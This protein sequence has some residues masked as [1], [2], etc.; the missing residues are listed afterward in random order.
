MVT[1]KRLAGTSCFSEALGAPRVVVR[2]LGPVAGDDF[3]PTETSIRDAIVAFP[4]RAA[5]VARVCA[6]LDGEAAA[7]LAADDGAPTKRVV[8]IDILLNVVTSIAG[9]RDGRIPA[10]VPESGGQSRINGVDLGDHFGLLLST[11]TL[12]FDGTVLSVVPTDTPH[13]LVRRRDAGYGAAHVIADTITIALDGVTVGLV[14][15]L[16]RAGAIDGGEIASDLGTYHDL[17]LVSSFVE[18]IRTQSPFGDTVSYRATRAALLHAGSGFETVASFAASFDPHDLY[19]GTR[20]FVRLL[21]EQGGDALTLTLPTAPGRPIRVKPD[22]GGWESEGAP[23]FVFTSQGQHDALK[24]GAREDLLTLVG[25]YAVEPLA[26]SSDGV[27]APS[28]SLDAAAVGLVPGFSASEAML[29]FSAADMAA[30][31][32]AKPLKVSFVLGPAFDPIVKP[33]EGPPLIEDEHTAALV[34]GTDPHLDRTSWMKLHRDGVMDLLAEPPSG[35]TL[36]G[37]ESAGA[38]ILSHA[39]LLRRVGSA[40]ETDAHAGF[41]PVLPPRGVRAGKL[42]LAKDF[43]RGLLARERRRASQAPRGARPGLAAM[44]VGAPRTTTTPLGFEIET[45]ESGSPT[46]IVFARVEIGAEAR[47]EAVFAL[48]GRDGRPLPSPVLDSL[49][50]NKLFLVANRMPDAVEAPDLVFENRINI[51]DYAFDVLLDAPAATLPIGATT[52]PFDTFVIVKNYAD[53]S[54]AEI[55]GDPS[56]WSGRGLFL[57]NPRSSGS[58]N[59]GQAASEVKKALEAYVARAGKIAGGETPPGEEA[60]TKADVA[61]FKRLFDSIL[62]DASWQGVFVIGASFNLGDLPPQLKGL[63]GGIDL[64]NLKAEYIAIPL[65]ALPSGGA[66]PQSRLQGLVDYRGPTGRPPAIE[67]DDDPPAGAAGSYGFDVPRLVVEFAR[68]EVLGFEARVRLVAKRLFHAIGNIQQKKGGTWKQADTI[69]LDGRYERRREGE[70]ML[71]S[72]VFETSTSYR[73]V[74]GSD[75]EGD[76]TAIV[77]QATLDRVAYETLSDD[78][79]GATKADVKSVFRINGDIAFGT[80]EIPGL[81]DLFNIDKIK[82]SDLRISCDF[83]LDLVNGVIDGLKKMS[84]RV[85]ALGFDFPNAKSRETGG[86][87]SSFPLKFRKFWMFDGPIDLPALGYF[88]FADFDAGLKFRFGFDFDLDLGT[89]GG[90]SSFKGLRLG[91]LFAFL[92]GGPSTGRFTLGFRFPEGDGSLDIGLQGFLKLKAERYGILDATYADGKKAK[93]L[94]SIGTQLQVLGQ[95][96]PAKPGVT[97]ALLVDPALIKSNGLGAVGWFAARKFDADSGKI[98]SVIDLELIALGQRVDPVHGVEVKTTKDFVE[99]LGELFAPGDKSG[100]ETGFGAG[101]PDPKKAAQKVV[102]VIEAGR[103]KFSPE[104]N[105]SLGFSAWI[106]DRVKIGLA[107]RDADIYGVR[108][109]LR[110][111]RT[112]SDPLFAVDVLYRK[113]SER[114]GVYSI[115]IVPP[116]SLRQIDL[117]WAVIDLPSIGIEIFTDGGFT[118]DVGYPHEMDYAPAFGVQIL[119]FIGSGG[120]YYRQVSGPGANLLPR[121]VN[122]K[123]N[124]AWQ[125]PDERVLA[126]SPVIEAGIA[127]RVGLGKEID[128]GIFKAGLSLTVFATLEGGF[129]RLKKGHEFEKNGFTT[130]AAA[131]FIAVRGTVGVMGEVYG[132]VDFGIVK[133]GVAIKLWVALGLDFKTDH[134]T[135]LYMQV[136]VSVDVRIVISSIKIFGKRVE[137]AISFSFATTVEYSTYLG[138]DR[139]LEYYRELTR[140]A[141]TL[142][143]AEAASSRLGPIGDLDWTRTLAPA[144]WRDV[145][146][147]L[148]FALRFSPDVTLAPNAGHMRPEAVM[149]LT[150]EVP[151]GTLTDIDAVPALLAAWAFRAAYGNGPIRDAIVSVDELDAL[152]TAVAE[153]PLQAASGGAAA[154]SDR[155]AYLP[156]AGAILS[157]LAANIAAVFENHP[158][159]GEPPPPPVPS[160]FWPIPPGTRIR[161]LGFTDDAVFNNVVPSDKRVVDDGYRRDVNDA[162]RKLMALTARDGGLAPAAIQAAPPPVSI[163]DTAFVE[164][165]VLLMRAALVRLVSLAHETV[166]SDSARPERVALGPLLDRLTAT[167]GSPG[168]PNAP[169][170]ARD[171]LQSAS[172]LFLHAPRLPFPPAAGTD[173]SLVPPEAANRAAHHGLFRLAWLQVPLG[174]G[175]ADRKIEVDID[176]GFG[177]AATLG[178]DAIDEAALSAFSALGRAVPPLGGAYVSPKLVR[179]ERRRFQAGLSHPRDDGGRL[180]MLDPLVTGVLAAGAVVA[181]PDLK[182]FLRT[183]PDDGNPLPALPADPGQDAVPADPAIAVRVRLSPRQAEGGASELDV[184]EILGMSEANRVRL[185]RYEDGGNADEIVDIK[186]YTVGDDALHDV[187]APDNATV[188]Q[189]DVSDEPKPDTEAGLATDAVEITATYVATLGDQKGAFVDIVRRTGIVNRGGTL[190]AWEGARA[191]FGARDSSTFEALMVLTLRHKAVGHANTMLIKPGHAT[192]DVDRLEAVVDGGV[193]TNAAASVAEPIAQAGTMP[194]AFV[195]EPPTLP[196]GTDPRAWDALTARFSMLAVGIANQDGTVLIEAGKTLAVGPT[197]TPDGEAGKLLFALP[198]TVSKLF[199]DTSPYRR[200]GETLTFH[201]LWR[202]VYGNDWPIPAFTAADVRITYVDR[203]IPLTDLPGLSIGWW[204]TTTPGALE[205]QFRVE[206]RWT[207]SLVPSAAVRGG[208]LMPAA[209]AELA[210]RLERSRA[211]YARTAEQIA[212]PLADAALTAAWSPEAASPDIKRKLGQF[213]A[214]ATDALT[215]LGALDFTRLAQAIRDDIDAAISGL[216]ETV[217]ASASVATTVQNPGADF[218]ELSLRLTVARRETNDAGGKAFSADATPDMRRYSMP[219]RLRLREDDAVD[220]HAPGGGFGGT[221]V[222]LQESVWDGF[223]TDHLVATGLSAIPG[224]GDRAVWLIRRAVLPPADHFTRGT[225]HHLALPPVS[226]RLHAVEFA[227]ETA[228]PVLGGS[229]RNAAFRGVDA[230]A[231]AARALAAYEQVLKPDIVDRLSRSPEGRAALQ[232]IVTA[233][234]GRPGYDGLATLLAS[235]ATPIFEHATLDPETGDLARRVLTDLLRGVLT[236]ADTIDTIVVLADPDPPAEIERN[237][238]QAYGRFTPSVDATA[239]VRPY[240]MTTGRQKRRRDLVM[241]VD[242]P[243]SFEGASVPLKGRYR[244]THVQR[245]PRPDVTQVGTPGRYRPAAWLALVP[246]P[247]E[248][249]PPPWLVDYGID[250]GEVPVIRRRYP[251]APALLVEAAIAPPW[252]PRTQIDRGVRAWSSSRTWTA[253]ADSVDRIDLVLRYN[254]GA[255][256]PDAVAPATLQEITW[257]TA[258]LRFAEVTHPA[259]QGARQSAPSSDDTKLAAFLR[260]ACQTL[261]DTLRTT[262]SQLSS[263]AVDICDKLTLSE[264]LSGGTRAITLLR[265]PHALV[266]ATTLTLDVMSDSATVVGSHEVADGNWANAPSTRDPLQMRRLGVEGADILVMRAVQTE[267]A[268]TRNA[269]IDGRAVDEPFV[270]RVPT[271]VSG[272]PVL[273]RIDIADASLATRSAAFETHLEQL[274]DAVIG[275]DGGPGSDALQQLALDLVLTFEPELA[276]GLDVTGDG[277][278]VAGIS[279]LDMSESRAT[280]IEPFDD[281][282]S[283]WRRTRGPTRGLFVFDVR[284]HERGEGL[285]ERLILRLRRVTLDLGLV[286]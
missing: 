177:A 147:K 242:A 215:T 73:Y 180:V 46:R 241:A 273:P 249:H 227:G 11:A 246:P 218:T 269:E 82:F 271:V 64:K 5:D 139:N 52:P 56:S 244:V 255:V 179:T 188:V 265:E 206:T 204:P 200:V 106:A 105:W 198:I 72:Y 211:I 39:P 19:D 22:G 38:T 284:L 202:D 54:I 9:Y 148:A 266:A 91:L 23:R 197:E 209:Q 119:P 259:L 26:V 67:A 214:E 159:H 90:L 183:M 87:W 88:S 234:A 83:L 161:R 257:A 20:S 70:K 122:F 217:S 260:D 58:S 124:D 224:V 76:P 175:A 113:L 205:I 150:S 98:G 112:S 238:P 135:R 163:A 10:L 137:I 286:A 128:K 120:L 174:A 60:P 157:I 178:I 110:E 97:F 96:F 145:A 162:F 3:A 86:L 151:N 170:P 254:P 189:V 133:A 117:G 237:G 275:P 164:H 232:A 17:G 129:G 77:R 31:A 240:V 118:I 268:L 267:L 6:W 61:R 230:D 278:H 7:Q 276:P 27:R 220:R 102:D 108:V 262:I 95:D 155:P 281:A 33:A 184:F 66:T 42:D 80:V 221:L 62:N 37:V 226:R 219:I 89:L 21:P 114:L 213:L 283:E 107:V 84:F 111:S 16:G 229:P 125:A 228:L 71:E 223:A 43:D 115:E 116:E 208:T 191:G 195:R 182:L 192:G 279:R 45:D 138:S 280:W 196:Y 261:W 263:V 143:L 187:G 156:E 28:E 121:L 231:E 142:A 256:R 136:G 44:A 131:T 25:D 59:Q 41:L 149:M 225:A 127:F 172:R 154:A 63:L 277:L 75:P 190:L 194:A 160:V 2:P 186:F 57:T 247:D 55:V 68:G 282:V 173:P 152:A 176:A 50:R 34:G 181:D 169:G 158:V 146:R 210:T 272:A 123:K 245:L 167:G 65:K 233:K 134:R 222:E 252:P 270:Y 74:S 236:R 85:G 274:L 250:A 49:V 235:R 81:P 40:A 130:E 239:T 153:G 8:F 103:I 264:I 243:P 101:E 140:A 203:L 48:R 165:A 185:D 207:E 212:D 35:R 104:R 15:A 30:P 100:A 69:D 93:A 199:G 1:L 53:R 132:Y 12:R 193:A 258:F 166:V 251:V 168:V 79:V 248:A 36:E 14:R 78:K 29:P 171:I 285:S 32:V 51:G 24:D 201:G 92:D 4:Q 47:S 94:Y 141:G 18:L 109:D 216:S 13:R 99:R 144:D 253:E 126:Y